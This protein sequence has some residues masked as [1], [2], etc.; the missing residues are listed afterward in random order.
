MQAEP[1]QPTTHPDITAIKGYE[2]QER[3]GAGGFGAV[4]KAYQSTVG[5]EVAIKVILPHYAN[6]PDFIRRFESE[7][8]TIARLEHM[9]IIPL[10][11]YWRDPDGA[12][13]VMRWLRGGSLKDALS[14]D[15][16][17]DLR[18]AT[19][20]LDQ[21]ASALAVAHRNDVVHRDLKPGNILLDEDGNAYLADFG[22]AK[23]LGTINEGITGDMLLGS[24]DYI[25]PE[26]A[27]SETATTQSDIYSLGVVLYEALTSQH[28]FPKSNPVER[29]FKHINEPLPD[30]KWADADVNA[31]LQKATA[32][33]PNNRYS[34]VLEFAAAFREA[35]RLTPGDS[36]VEQ[37]TR[38]E[39]E[40]LQCIINGS[41][42]K[43]IATEL[44]ITVST[45]KWYVKQ[46]YKKLGVRSRV[47]AIVRARELNLIVNNPTDTAEAEDRTVYISTTGMQEVE[48]PYKGLRPFTAAD[49]RDFFGRDKLTNKLLK[50]ISEADDGRFVAVI[51]PSGSGKSSLVKAGLIPALW[52]G[53]LPGSERWFVVDM[54]PGSHPV[55]ELEI[56]LTRVAADQ[57]ENLAAHLQRDERGLLRVAQLILPD[58]DSQLLLIIDQFEEVFTMV[59]DEDARAHFLDMLHT[60]A[61]DPRSR[62]RVV[63]TLRADFYDRP[64]H[65]HNFGNLVRNN[66][67]TVLPLSP[68]GL[69]QAIVG[70]AKRVG[71]TFAPG[72]AATIANEISYQPGAL[73]LLQYALTELFERR[74]GRYIS[75]D[76]FQ[77][78]GGTVGALAKRADE[79]YLEQNAQGREITRQLFLRLVT[80]GE[81][82]EDTRRRANHEEL[83]AAAGDDVDLMDEMI[84][85]FVEFRLLSM[86]NDPQTRT[87][88][89]EVAH[90][91]ILREWER[92]RQWLNDSREDIKSQRE[93]N[94]DA[95]KW[96]LADKDVSYLAHGSRLQ[97]FESW[98][99][100]TNLNMT[101][102]ERKYLDASL[103]YRVEQAELEKARAEREAQLEKRSRQLH[104]MFIAAL[105]VANIIAIFGIIY[106]MRLRNE[107]EDRRDQAAA[108]A[109]LAEERLSLSLSASSSNINSQGDP[110]LALSL[111]LEALRLDPDSIR[112]QQSLFDALG[113]ATT[114][115]EIVHPTGDALFVDVIFAPDNTSVIAI[116]NAGD[117]FRFALPDGT[118]LNTYTVPQPARTGSSSTR[119]AVLGV[120]DNDR[121]LVVGIG[122]RQN[123]PTTRRLSVLD[124]TTGEAVVLD[125]DALESIQVPLDLAI[126]GDATQVAGAMSDGSLTLWDAQ[127]GARLLN[128]PVDAANTLTSVEFSPD[129]RSVLAGSGGGKVHL[130]DIESAQVVRTYEA[131]NVGAIDDL[132]WTDE[133]GRALVTTFGNRMLQWDLTSGMLLDAMRVDAANEL[134]VWATSEVPTNADPFNLRQVDVNNY[135]VEQ[136]L[137]GGFM[138][139]MMLLHLANQQGSF[140]ALVNDGNTTTAIIDQNTFD[141]IQV[142]DVSLNSPTYVDFNGGSIFTPDDGVLLQNITYGGR[143]MLEEF[144]EFS[145]QPDSQPL[146]LNS[147]ATNTLTPLMDGA[148][149]R[150]A[151]YEATYSPA[152]DYL[153]AAS[154]RQDIVDSDSRL[155]PSSYSYDLHLVDLATDTD[156]A[157]DVHVDTLL[158]PDNVPLTNL[159]FAPEGNRFAAVFEYV[160]DTDLPTNQDPAVRVWDT[161]GNI[162]QTW[163]VDDVGVARALTWSSD[164][165]LIIVN[166]SGEIVQISADDT[167]TRTS[168]TSDILM[169]VT[170][171]PDDSRLIVSSADGTMIVY[172]RSMASVENRYFFHDNTVMTL[173]VHPDGNLAVSGDMAGNALIWRID[174]GLVVKRFEHNRLPIVGEEASA[175]AHAEF[176]ESGNFLLLATSYMSVVW[177]V[178][179]YHDVNNAVSYAQSFRFQPD[180]TCAQRIEFAISPLCDVDD[181]NAFVPLATRTA[182]PLMDTTAAPAVFTTREAPAL[183]PSPILPTNTPTQS[184][185]PTSTPLPVVRGQL[186]IGDDVR[187]VLTDGGHIYTIEV[188]AGTRLRIDFSAALQVV[189]LAGPDGDVMAVVGDGRSEFTL[190]T[191]GTY[192]IRVL[193]DPQRGPYL[194]GITERTD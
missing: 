73:P 187:D 96:L 3:I 23:D 128:L 170:I 54:M 177:Q 74:D 192:T 52:R 6:H 5:R 159:S 120:S 137:D 15:G 51:G 110:N 116:D 173:D 127:T 181:N 56:A 24:P 21:I 84:N 29:I 9:H 13:L 179:P 90:E 68:E 186:T 16:A 148:E 108:N 60:A 133:P 122:V 191:G 97:L 33:N 184:P 1:V 37:L 76:A 25:A 19:V 48:N 134:E 57:A 160:L 136:W 89:V 18:A 22:I 167:I 109:Q 185:T 143:R 93:L 190:Q 40:V 106:V 82:T 70:P 72:L 147:T 87:P 12:Y 38:R 100:T 83:M 154:S 2:I 144:L 150:S 99:M 174:N 135:T 31:V 123:F 164:G 62:V 138:Q 63:I 14:K 10:Y 105:A 4:Y 153:I 27:R 53:D 81:G 61:T 189:E 45:V 8:Q 101:S 183:T 44:F 162:V 172:H 152:G 47:Q 165:T 126:S 30:I 86:D 88:T 75:H 78:I 79:I 140:S 65:Y 168:I 111:A 142:Y 98:A 7:A 114:V 155:L 42:N 151:F 145:D 59:E 41:T 178:P 188:A 32:K 146:M 50:H 175:I 11:D 94:T 117:I 141:R 58:D 113:A 180:F 193:P 171:T 66:L 157:V 69:E 131:G 17:F 39:Q 112:A 158:E 64:L 121:Y 28:P 71:V 36:V 104:T 169:D 156:I 95:E 20:L 103:A 194:L 166:I 26:Q 119:A 102:R 34:D 129:Q 132:Y 49:S 118:L 46:I 85:A 67:V 80:L 176:D 125:Y 124:M 91:A 130:I 182:A 43:E 92:L 161:T 115:N 149:G 77:E 35:V 163:S 55:D 107:A 139:Q